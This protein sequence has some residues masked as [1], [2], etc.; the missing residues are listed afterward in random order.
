[1]VATVLVLGAG[2]GGLELCSRLAHELGDEVD[3]TLIDRNDG[4]LFGFSKLD[5]MFG[6]RE[7]GEVRVPYAELTTPH[8]RFRRET[9][10]SIDPA[11]RRVVTD[12]DVH[13]A[14]TLVVALGA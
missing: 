13:E 11:A 10:T 8:V 3:V 6:K 12:A 2:F 5:V 1:M 14:D 7:P 4:F 9:V